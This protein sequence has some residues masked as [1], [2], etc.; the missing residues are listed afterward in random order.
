VTTIPL[1]PG[2]EFDRVR[3]I[4]AALGPVMGAV[5]D[6]TATIPEGKGSIVVSVDA[7]VEGVHF[8]RE[9]LSLEE[10]G[11]RATAGA[12]SDLAAVGATPVGVV[13][14]V[15]VPRETSEAS[16]IELMRGVGAAIESVGAKLLGG[17]LT[18]GR[19]WTASVTVIGRAVAPVSRSGATPGDGVWVTGVLGGARA[20]LQ[21]WTTAVAPDAASRSAFAHPVPRIAAGQWLAAHGATAMIDLSD[22]LGGDAAHLAAASRVRIELELERLPLHSSVVAAAR[23]I[24]EAP[25]IFAATAGE[26]YELLVTLPPGFAEVAGFTR[27]CGLALTRIGTVATGADLHA[28]LSGVVQ[29]VHGFRHAV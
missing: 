20:A 21:A 14:A 25:E 23:H 9:W 19:Q 2:G 26:D 3:A 13:V 27:D 24:G 1:G 28:T 7:S 12:L 18:S 16:L 8:R 4:A 29:S 15:V 5:G 11:W 10:I 6:D 22:G 17:D